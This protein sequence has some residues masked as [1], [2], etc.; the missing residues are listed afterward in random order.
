VIAT[1]A[2]GTPS[3]SVDNLDNDFYNN[4]MKMTD[5]KGTRMLVVIGYFIAPKLM[6]ALKIPFLPSSLKTYFTDII[7]STIKFREENNKSRPDM[8]QMLLEERKSQFHK[9]KEM[10]HHINHPNEGMN[11]HL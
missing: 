6:A 9:L 7:S 2:F 5:F 11:Y 3:N 10:G 4:G 1:T 8:I